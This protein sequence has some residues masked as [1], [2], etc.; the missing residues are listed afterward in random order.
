M[1]KQRLVTGPL[2]ILLL[3]GAVLLDMSGWCAPPVA[4]LT[5]AA[6]FAAIGGI[7]MTRLLEARHGASLSPVAG[8]IGAAAMTLA[9]WWA[10]GLATQNQPPPGLLA[11]VPMGALLLAFVLTALS[12]STTA[13]L[14]HASATALATVWVGGGLGMLMGIYA[15]SGPAMLLIIVLVT[16]FADI[17]A[18][19]VGCTMGRHKL[20]PWISPK[21]TW[22]GLAGGLVTASLVCFISFEMLTPAHG[23]DPADMGGRLLMAG[24]LGVI[25]GIAGLVGD[26]TVSMLKRDARVKDSGTLLPGMGGALDVLDSLL[27]AGPVAWVIIVTQA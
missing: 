14:G 20:I 4:L 24:I 15:S 10:V 18:Y 6:L 7:E 27:V 19:T 5:I 17:G 22:E 11:M 1:L 25:I 16:K 3:V 9:T 8:A 26:L 12:R 23:A 2:L 21:K 13:S